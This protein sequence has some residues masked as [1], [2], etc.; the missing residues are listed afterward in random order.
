VIV[1]MMRG[2]AARIFTMR[3]GHCASWEAGMLQRRNL[4]HGEKPLSASQ[5]CHRKCLKKK[6]KFLSLI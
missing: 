5:K 3:R 4:F 1:R 2:R 6:E